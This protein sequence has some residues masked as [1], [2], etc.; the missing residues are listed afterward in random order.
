MPS[1]RF[2]RTRIELGNAQP[3]VSSISARLRA[4]VCPAVQI[5]TTSL[6]AEIPACTQ[7]S[8]SLREH[9]ETVTDDHSVGA[10]GKRLRGEGDGQEVA[11]DRGA[12]IVVVAGPPYR[13]L[14]VESAFGGKKSVTTAPA[15]LLLSGYPSATAASSG[16]TCTTP[17]SA[18]GLVDQALNG[19][20]E[21]KMEIGMIEIVAQNAVT[22]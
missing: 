19:G 21:P 12:D 22:G 20:T 2:R 6:A 16:R 11:V 1:G 17:N 9:L 7:A 8:K 15:W 14:R 10:R 5:V 4:P 18:W 3:G 13:G